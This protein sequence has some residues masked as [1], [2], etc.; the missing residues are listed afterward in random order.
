MLDTD[1]VEMEFEQDE[2]VENVFSERYE[3]IRALKNKEVV[4]SHSAFN[5][6]CNSPRHFLDYK[7]KRFEP[8]P[9]MKFGTMVHCAILEPEKFED[10]FYVLPSS[11]ERP[12]QDKNM[13]SKIN[14]AWKAEMMLNANGREIVEAKDY[15]VA[16]RIG[17]SIRKSDVASA[18]LEKC[19]DF[20]SKIEWEYGGF[21]WQGRMDGDGRRNGVIMDLKVL[22]DAS[23]RKVSSYVKYEGAGRQAVH[24]LRGANAIDCDYYIL[25][26][27]RSGNYS[28][29]KIG[30]GL[31]NQLSREIDWYLAR[32]KSCIFT[33]D[34]N[35]SY[36][37]YGNQDG[38]FEINSL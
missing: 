21:K 1:D 33:G 29:S 13:N 6:F 11:D 28:V 19:H 35:A 8:T 18:L 22:A 17:D 3:L 32:F 31:I 15:E 25:A 38:H 20:E 4:L 16:K 34:W 7:L 36:D 23:P 5:A 26:V 12:E 37:F 24:Y 9:S 27:E 14:Q 30:Q 10:T 2:P